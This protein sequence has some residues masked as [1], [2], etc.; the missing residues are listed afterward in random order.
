M[1]LLAMATAYLLYR[2]WTEAEWNKLEHLLLVIIL[3]V[4]MV[5]SE[6]MMRRKKRDKFS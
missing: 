1:V 6:I 3:G 4:G 2:L 5:N